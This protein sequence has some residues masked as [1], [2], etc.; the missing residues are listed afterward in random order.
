MPKNR[1]RFDPHRF[2]RD[3]K[4]HLIEMASIVSLVIVLWKILNHEW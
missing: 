4:Y 2:Y 1:P 3:L